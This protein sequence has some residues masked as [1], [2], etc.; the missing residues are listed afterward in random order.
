MRESNL[1]ANAVTYGCI[2]D[3]CVKSNRVDM[4]E[5]VFECMVSD[6]VALNTVIYTTMIKGYSRAFKL[7]ESL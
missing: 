4:A 3:A 6:R 1:S 5:K 2:L 7:S